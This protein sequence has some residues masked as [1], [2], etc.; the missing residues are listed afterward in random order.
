MNSRLNALKTVLWAIVG[1][2]AVVSVARFAR[3][4]GA[5]TNL[6]DG[7]PWGLWIGFD[8]MA[9]VALAAGGF[10]I[11]ATVYIFGLER[12]RP[13]ARPAI[14]TA[15]L[16]YSAVA[17]GLLY[18]L[19]LPWHIWHPLINWQEHSV[20]FEVAACVMT[21]LTVLTLEFA[22][23]I[24]E[25][26]LFH[27]RIFKAVYRILKKIT[28]PLVI[29]GIV[30]STLHQSSLGSLFLIT[31][32]RLHPL[33]YSP[34]IYLLFFISAVGLGL[35][36]VILESL[37]SGY[38]FKHKIDKQRVAGLAAAA[39]VVLGLY[40]VVRLGDTAVRGLLPQAFSGDWH[41]NLFLFELAVSAIIP[42]VL[43]AIP[44][45]RHSIGGLSAAS[46]LTVLGM[47]GY[48]LDTCIVAFMR[49]EEASYFPNWMEFAITFGIV[50]AFGLIFVF[51]VEHLRVFEHHAEPK[52]PAGR[53]FPIPVE[54]SSVRDFGQ[55]AWH[56]PVWYSLVAITTATIT[57][58]ILPAHIRT[59]AEY[60]AE[61]VSG[62]R[63]ILGLRLT[64]ANQEGQRFAV[65]DDQ[66][67]AQLA[68]LGTESVLLMAIDG[69][70]DGNMVLFDHES[71][72]AREG[73]PDSWEEGCGICHHMNKPFDHNTSCY[74]CHSDMYEPTNIF[75]HTEHTRK[76]G[77]N[78]GC[79]RCHRNPDEVKTAANV[80][81]C[82]TCHAD[83]L[84]TGSTLIPPP[85]KEGKLWQAPGYRDAM[86]GSCIKCH[87][88]R[89]KDQPDAYAAQFVRCDNCHNVDYDTELHSLSPYAALPQ[90]E[91][92]E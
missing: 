7:A 54:A 37:L 52:A 79:I 36:M 56:G 77:G 60:R 40:A 85:P 5:T 67:G 55:R 66:T 82:L 73:D 45:I 59:G 34:I 81:P 2:W 1:V 18:D 10:V 75:D 72:R 12:Y 32:G 31:P 49:P 42:A 35:M 57:F 90:T 76:L 61:S 15:F 27:H 46:A 13:F 63:T 43:M 47:I 44:R 19:G 62:T 86:H 69:N 51:F 68:A 29:A 3:G 38:F 87:E 53:R 64:H 9:G 48:R 26:P 16:G 4:L 83:M 92:G 6:S 20:L 39:A 23:V 28:I 30:L 71:H 50:A 11:A 25:H 70:R 41:G 17:V 24:L 22:P 88:Q 65:P 78:D 74:E 89:M 91:G 21:Y 58:L 80:A 84:A 14:L 8:V 33:W